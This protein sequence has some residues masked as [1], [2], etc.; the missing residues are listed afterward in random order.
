MS[1]LVLTYSGL[2]SPLG[3]GSGPGS[4]CSRLLFW[5]LAIVSYTFLFRIQQMVVQLGLERLISVEP[6]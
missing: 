3:P 6:F 1:M 2:S 5:N 4:G